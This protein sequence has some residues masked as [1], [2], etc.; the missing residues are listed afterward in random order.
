MLR[1]QRATIH[2]R[3]FATTSREDA[4]AVERAVATGVGRLTVSIAGVLARPRVRGAEEWNCQ[5]GK[6]KPAPA[7]MTRV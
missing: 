3:R 5:A 7:Q 1:Y 2:A 6:E 4:K